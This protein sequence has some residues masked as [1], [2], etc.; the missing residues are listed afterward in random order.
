LTLAEDIF[1]Q[2]LTQ[3][4]KTKDWRIEANLHL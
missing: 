3:N 1:V 4:Q 2:A